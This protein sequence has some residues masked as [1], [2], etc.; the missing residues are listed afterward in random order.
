M[1]TH[2]KWTDKTLNKP[3]LKCFRNT[4]QN[5]FLLI[6]S[7]QSQIYNTTSNG[8]QK[9]DN[10]INNHAN[11]QEVWVDWFS[12]LH[13]AAGAGQEVLDRRGHGLGQV[14]HGAEAAARGAVVEEG[15]DPR[16]RVLLQEVIPGALGLLQ[17]GAD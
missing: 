1:L 15:A 13:L 14:G 7:K 6:S 9:T 10:L 16:G 11:E 12:S 4:Q 8:S 17:V 2:F 5:T 3:N